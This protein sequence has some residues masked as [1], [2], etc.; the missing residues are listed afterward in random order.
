VGRFLGFEQPQH[1]IWCAYGR[2]ASQNDDDMRDGKAMFS[3][4]HY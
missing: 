4:G 1:T 3:K 2:T